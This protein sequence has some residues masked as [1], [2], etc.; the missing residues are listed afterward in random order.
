MKGLIESIPNTTTRKLFCFTC[1]I[2]LLLLGG[3]L[4]L[5]SISSTW[6]GY[7]CT[8]WPTADGTVITSE[9]TQKPAL[10]DGYVYSP[11]VKY[12]YGVGGVTLSGSTIKFGEGYNRPSAE[13]AVRKYPK[14]ATIAVH[15]NPKNPEESVLEPGLSWGMIIFKAIAGFLFLLLGLS[16]FSYLSPEESVH[17]EP[18]NGGSEADAVS[19]PI[20]KSPPSTT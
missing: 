10:S 19:P 4:I 1:G 9:V 11:D 5:N 3:L 14:G 15:Y 7:Q 6:E 20:G 17:G 8:R 12:D 13:E 2:S 16:A 18:T